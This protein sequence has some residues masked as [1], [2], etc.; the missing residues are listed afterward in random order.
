MFLPY[1]PTRRG[2]TPFYQAQEGRLMS[3]AEAQ[4]LAN[5][6]AAED[7]DPLSSYGIVEVAPEQY[8]V[9]VYRRPGRSFIIPAPGTALYLQ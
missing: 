8:A 6:Y 2:S 4:F 7:Q 1:L 9:V 3:A 5:R